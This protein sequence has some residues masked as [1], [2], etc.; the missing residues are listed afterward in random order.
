MQGLYNYIGI[1]KIIVPLHACMCL[2]IDL[3]KML[4]DFSIEIEW[5]NF[6]V[7]LIKCRYSL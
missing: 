7:S 5:S 1:P 2:L 6:Q 3:Y 4:I